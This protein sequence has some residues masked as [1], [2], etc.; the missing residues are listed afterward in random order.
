MP[1]LEK[2]KNIMENKTLERLEL[3]K[4]LAGVASFAVLPQTK[5]EIMREQPAVLL[6]DA[7]KALDLTS[8]ADAA[9]FRYGAGRIEEFPEQTEELQRA[10]KGASLSCKELL[11][12]ALLLR[13]ARVAFKSVKSLQDS[14]LLNE[15][16]DGIYFDEVLEK[17]ITDKILSEDEISDYASDD[18]YN[19]RRSIRSLNERIRSRLSEYLSG[20]GA[21]FLQEGIVTMRDNRYVLPV[22]AEYKSRIRGFVHDRS[23]SGATFF[24]EPEQILE[25]NNELRELSAAEK[26]E[27]ERIL[28]QLSHRLGTLTDQLLEDVVRLSDLDR[29][30]AKAEYSYKNKCTRPRLND[31]G[32]IDIQKGRHPLLDA[33][34]AVP[35]SVALGK[36]YDI[37][38]V[39]GPNTGG[40]TV[41]LKMCGLFCLMA[42]CGIFLPAADGT[43]V[44]VFKKIFCDI[45][46]AQ[47]IEENLSTFSSH[48]KNII[49]ITREADAESLVLIDELGG[50]TDPE[51]GQALAKAIISHLLRR[52][53]KG[54]VT[55]HYTSLKEFAYAAKGIENASMEFDMNTLQ[56]LYKI[57]LGIPGSSNAIAISRRLGLSSEIL[58]EA[59]A[60]LSEGGRQ[61]ENILRTAEQSRIEAEEAKRQAEQLKT[62]WSTKLSE[63]NAEREKLKKE[64][65]KLFLSAK[66]E[67]RRIVN[68]RT[69]QAEELLAQIEEIAKRRDLTEADLIRARTLKNK[70]ADKAYL[71]Q[72]E[73]EERPSS[74]PVDFASLKKG[75]KV[76]VGAMQS[77]GEVLSVNPKKQEA[78]VLVGS[79]R[80]NV[81]GKDLFRM[82]EPV[83]RKVK[84][85]IANV[86]VNRKIE[87]IQNVKTEINLIGLTV[88]EAVQEVDAFIDQAV[89]AGLDEVKIIH[90]MG[91]GKLK[92]G[93]R[94]HLRGMKN[95]AEFRSGVYGEGEAGVTIVKLK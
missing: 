92:E 20:E 37:L 14:P 54:I 58:D 38:L 93:I 43:E 91:T 18:L 15:I 8:E 95:V 60:N 17:D 51:E 56:P 44:S 74:A 89:L 71:A 11:N 28:A 94:N 53:S 50:G 76:F 79:I 3:N 34:T 21:K 24:I 7:R 32:V 30:Y 9:L 5:E 78:E 85:P 12:A 84:R 77:S 10:Q 81:K 90:G 73:E 48:I 25:M 59:V 88:S 29:A 64:R 45:G 13:S 62:E 22:R 16:A 75:D 4:I 82:I 70:L 26:E 63:V 67:S 55:T 66:M 49:G 39:S 2:D 65:E 35:V 19:I 86:Q 1:L 83:K 80:L 42:C 69:E 68:E 6:Q 31:R 36:D 33:K 27:I 46:D 23:A 61:F 57:T 41:T 72:T 40:K 52:K 87:P 47:S